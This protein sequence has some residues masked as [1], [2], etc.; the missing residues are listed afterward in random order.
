MDKVVDTKLTK[1]SSLE[2]IQKPGVA[3][4]GISEDSPLQKLAVKFTKYP[5]FW[6]EGESEFK[7]EV[8]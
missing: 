1:V 6:I 7:V 8:H 5:I 2:H 4:F 3:V